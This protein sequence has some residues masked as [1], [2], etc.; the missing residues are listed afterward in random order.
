MSH[1]PFQTTRYQFDKISFVDA[2]IWQNKCQL[3]STISEESIFAT[4]RPRLYRVTKHCPGIPIS[5]TTSPSSCS[6]QSMMPYLSLCHTDKY[7][8]QQ[9]M[10]KYSLQSM[11]YFTYPRYDMVR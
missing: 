4:L 8:H 2:R 7:K 9:N 6:L 11:Y 3:N 10:T 1:D 5:C